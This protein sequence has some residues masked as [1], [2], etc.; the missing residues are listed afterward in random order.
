MYI[1]MESKEDYELSHPQAID[2][3]NVSLPLLEAGVESPRRE[4]ERQ[5]ARH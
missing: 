2:L 3:E 5:R 4:G 1:E